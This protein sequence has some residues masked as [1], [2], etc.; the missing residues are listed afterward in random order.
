MRLIVLPT[1][2]RPRVLE[3]IQPASR[4]FCC[5]KLEIHRIDIIPCHFRLILAANEQSAKMKLSI[6]GTWKKGTWLSREGNDR[7]YEICAGEVDL[8][9]WEVF[10]KFPVTTRWLHCHKIIFPVSRSPRLKPH[11]SLPGLPWNPFPLS[12]LLLLLGHQAEQLESGQ[13]A[14]AGTDLAASWR[15]NEVAGS[16]Y[17][18]DWQFWA[19]ISAFKGPCLTFENTS[20]NLTTDSGSYFEISIF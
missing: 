18:V 19:D 5:I 3:M 12:R 13:Q 16:R 7:S 6:E 14:A 20:D 4:M 1:W 17:V 10:P 8:Q 15:T 2:N 9:R 11:Q